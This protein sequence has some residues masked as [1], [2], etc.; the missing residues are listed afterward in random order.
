METKR[1]LSFAKYVSLNM[2][3]MLGLS[4]YILADTFFVSAALGTPGLAALNLAIPVYSLISGVGLMLGMGGGAWYGALKVRGSRE[5][6]NRVFTETLALGGFF[7]SVFLLAGIF[8]AEY[9]AGILGASDLILSMT[10]AYLRTILCFSPCFLLNNILLAFLRNDG[11]PRL[12]MAAML[13]GSFSNILLDYLFLFPLRWGMFGAAFAT[14]LSPVIGIAVLST[15]LWKGNRGFSVVAGRMSLRLAVKICGAGLSALV[16][17]FS[18][19]VTLAVFNL[20]FLRLAGNTGVAAY[21]IVANLAL[22]ETALFT[23]E[24]QG[25]QP[26]VS[27]V[28]GLGEKEEERR[29]LKKGAVLALFL[30]MVLYGIVFFNAEFL[31]RVFNGEQD[32]VLA[33]MAE[34]GMRLYFTGYFLGGFNILASAFFSASGKE[35]SGFLVSM[36]RGILALLPSAILFSMVGGTTGLWLSFPAS[37]LLGF[38]CFLALYGAAR[39]KDRSAGL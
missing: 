30:S 21:G 12:A 3:G 16:T 20:L 35:K 23:G 15:G 13:A 39:K 22:V 36:L 18:S 32:P 27:H 6:Q 31:T 37:E 9:M 19:A 7:S 17:E 8:L 10:A 5:E 34:Q 2:L 1:E 14:G 26:L 33:Q 38:V 24:A 4:C 28:Y 11:A 25:I 29:L